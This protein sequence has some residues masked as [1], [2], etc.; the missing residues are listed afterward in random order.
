[1]N[2]IGFQNGRSEFCEICSKMQS[3]FCFTL[4]DWR[5][6][7]YCIGKCWSFKQY[8]LAFCTQQAFQRCLNVEQRLASTLKWRWILVG[9]ESWMD[10]EVP[11]LLQRWTTDAVS[12]LKSRHYLDV[13]SRW[14]LGVV[15]TLKS[16]RCFNLDL[17][18]LIF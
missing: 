12:T 6:S 10:I 17:T 8:G 18:F 15:S 4:F 16:Q 14:N 13:V 9:F 11:T 7:L 3:Y 5:Q 2:I 1:M